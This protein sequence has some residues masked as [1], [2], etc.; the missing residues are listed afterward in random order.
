MIRRSFPLAA[1]ALAIALSVGPSE[2]RAQERELDYDEIARR[3]GFTVTKTIEN[4]HEVVVIR[5]A[6]VEIRIDSDHVMGTDKD[7]AVGC[8]WGLYVNLSVGADYCFPDARNELREDLADAVERMKDFI[9]ANNLTPITRG[10]LDAYVRER[11]AELI[12]RMPKGEP[13]CALD[14]FSSLLPDS[15]E[16]RRAAVA[17]ALAVPRPPVLNPCL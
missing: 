13:H 4:G 1:A 6:T 5:K 14:Y 17:E 2:M 9:V 7:V 10:E 3:P 16:K 8:M 12:A 15:R 11:R